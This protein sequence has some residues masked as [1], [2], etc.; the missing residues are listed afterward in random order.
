[1]EP[2]L[3]GHC[4]LEIN[5]F[6]ISYTIIFYPF[7][8]HFYL[9]S[10]SARNNGNKNAL[11]TGFVLQEVTKFMDFSVFESALGR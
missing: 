9:L 10:R 4:S 11:G 3:S 8:F 6:H 7:H 1:M 5:I 2:T